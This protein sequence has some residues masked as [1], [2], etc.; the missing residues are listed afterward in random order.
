MSKKKIFS[1]F[2][3]PGIMSLISC[4]IGF[5]VACALD[6]WEHGWVLFPVIFVI[7][8]IAGEIW[9]YKKRK[10]LIENGELRPNHPYAIAAF[11]L[12]SISMLILIASIF[13]TI[14]VRRFY[15]DGLSWTCYNG[16]IWDTISLPVIAIILSILAIF[17]AIK[18]KRHNKHIPILCIF[19][20]LF[21]VWC[22]TTFVLP[23]V[24]GM[25][26]GLIQTH[27][28]TRSWREEQW[29]KAMDE[30]AKMNEGRESVNNESIDTT[31]NLDSLSGL[32]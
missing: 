16:L 17:N 29:H 24:T 7:G 23:L 2:H 22:G 25:N 6:V 32:K 26:D 13:A 30:W 8:S 10:P 21:V 4:L 15:T 9:Q 18:H 3:Y 31:E 1:R 19:L 11:I 12:I 14:V 20:A 27:H 28:E 5:G